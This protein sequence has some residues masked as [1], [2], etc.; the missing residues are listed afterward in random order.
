MLT[1]KKYM[2]GKQL[3]LISSPAY[4][5]RPTDHTYHYLSPSLHRQYLD[6]TVTRFDLF[7]Y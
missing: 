7:D 6:N 4:Q 3:N 1:E 2:D 5:P